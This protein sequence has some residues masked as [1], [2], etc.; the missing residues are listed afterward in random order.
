MDGGQNLLLL[1][2]SLNRFSLTRS[3]RVGV[4]TTT[5]SC[6][7]AGLI[8]LEN[9][10]FCIHNLAEKLLNKIMSNPPGVL[11]SSLCRLKLVS[12]TEV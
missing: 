11:G 7:A 3:R 12:V 1:P 4:R 9:N 10:S 5:W 2:L 6:C 8:S